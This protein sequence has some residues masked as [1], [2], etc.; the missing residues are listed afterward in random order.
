MAMD[1]GRI[2]QNACLRVRMC[3][4]ERH[5]ALLEELPPD[6]VAA[7]YPIYRA[8]FHLDFDHTKCLDAEVAPALE[9]LLM[10]TSCLLTS[11][12][13]CPEMFRQFS[14]HGGFAAVLALLDTSDDYYVLLAVL[15]VLNNAK[16]TELSILDPVELLRRLLATRERL[17]M[18][19]ASPCTDVWFLRGYWLRVVES[20]LKRNSFSYDVRKQCYDALVEH[21]ERYTAGFSDSSDL[22]LVMSALRLVHS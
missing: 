13:A 4:L 10:A 6:A 7:A 22:Y 2:L 11:D 12:I 5:R 9:K 1:Y 19:D 15:I 16:I 18:N 17:A 8:R 3:L 20:L 14:V 21:L